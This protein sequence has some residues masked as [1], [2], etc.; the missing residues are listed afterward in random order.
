MDLQNP[1]ACFHLH[2]LGPKD[3]TSDFYLFLFPPAEMAQL[4]LD[5]RHREGHPEL[6]GF[7]LSMFSG[8]VPRLGAS[9]ITRKAE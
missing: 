7:C 3:F 8:Q 2:E 9:A 5:H 1:V 4:L 6:S